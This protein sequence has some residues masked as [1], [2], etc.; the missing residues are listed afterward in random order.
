MLKGRGVRVE[1]Y[2]GNDA[3]GWYWN[4]AELL[5]EGTETEA[6]AWVAAQPAQESP[7]PMGI[8]VAGAG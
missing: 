8:W 2:R 3:E 1:V 7:L 4:R 5:F 6:E